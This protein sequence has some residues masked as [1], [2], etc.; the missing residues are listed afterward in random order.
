MWHSFLLTCF[1]KILKLPILIENIKDV[2]RDLNGCN[3]CLCKCHVYS[4]CNIIT[5]SIMILWFVL[6]QE[7]HSCAILYPF[8]YSYMFVEITEY[9]FFSIQKEESEPNRQLFLILTNISLVLQIW[10]QFFTHVWPNIFYEY[11]YYY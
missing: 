4:L 7:T 6:C 8:V 11:Y 10:M 3:C 9:V 2:S 5:T 1:K